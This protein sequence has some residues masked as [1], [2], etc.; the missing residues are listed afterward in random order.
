MS[1]LRL[2]TLAIARLE[3]ENKIREVGQNKGPRIAEYQKEGNTAPG[4]PYCASF[5]NWCAAAAA[6]ILY[7]DKNKSPLEKVPNQAYVQSYV[8]HFRI[9]GKIIKDIR[10]VKPGMLFALYIPYKHRYGHIGLVD[11]I[12]SVLDKEY[13]TAEGNTSDSGTDEGE[14]VMSLNRIQGVG[15]IFID[16]SGD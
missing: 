3:V 2:K 13:K 6:K 1:S 4:Q 7:G 14:G 15:T 5:V 12:L 10:Q 8:D 9:R 11:S 16:W